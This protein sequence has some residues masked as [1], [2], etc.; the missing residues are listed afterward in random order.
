MDDLLGLELLRVVML[1]C[2]VLARRLRIALPVLLLIGG[3]RVPS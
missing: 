1:A 2:S 3:A